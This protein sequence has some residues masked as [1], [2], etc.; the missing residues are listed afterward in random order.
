MRFN[1]VG[2]WFRMQL[3]G[4]A[5]VCA[6]RIIVV[7]VVYRLA[8]SVVPEFHHRVK[9]WKCGK[10]LQIVLTKGMYGSSCAFIGE[11]TSVAAVRLA[12]DGA[13]G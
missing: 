9:T 12:M 3:V 5:C 10:R 11:T 8:T 6:F 2:C 13:M 7:R 4:F 1:G